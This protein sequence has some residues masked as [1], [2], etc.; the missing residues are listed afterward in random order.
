VLRYYGTDSVLQN[1]PL[2]RHS[3][4]LMVFATER[5]GSIVRAVTM[6]PVDRA[7][8]SGDLA[9]CVA[10]ELT[11]AMGLSND[12]LK[13]FPSIFSRKSSHAFLTGLDYLILKMLYDARVKPGMDEKT[14][15]PILQ[16]IA[17]EYERDNRFNV[18]ERL[19]AEGGLSALSP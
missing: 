4:C 10:E 18:V 12:S 3:I 15:R 13:V 14:V 16:V 1:E 2:F 7:R 11:H 19:A 5:K 6:I 17:G 8:A 9:S